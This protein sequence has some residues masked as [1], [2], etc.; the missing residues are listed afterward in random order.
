[1]KFKNY[2]FCCLALSFLVCCFS[3]IEAGFVPGTF[4]PEMSL[5]L[6][7]TSAEV[8]ELLSGKVTVLVY[9]ASAGDRTATTRIIFDDGIT[10]V[11]GDC[12]AN[13]EM[14]DDFI[15]CEFNFMH[16]YDNPGIYNLNVQATVDAWAAGGGVN[17]QGPSKTITIIEKTD[18]TASSTGPALEA[19]STVAIIKR[20][21]GILYWVIASLFVLLIMFGGFTIITSSGNPEQ[22]TKGRTIILYAVVGLAIMVAARG[23]IAFIQQVIGVTP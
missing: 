17:T 18:I 20:A 21:A 10:L 14:P 7:R 1:M 11:L 6:N 15:E 19:T 2:L 4:A 3:F 5:H 23:I 22:I 13:S 9:K 8:N 12:T 16:V